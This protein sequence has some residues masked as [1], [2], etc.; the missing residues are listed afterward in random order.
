[1]HSRR[2][3][4]WPLALALALGATGAVNAADAPKITLCPGFSVVTAI[5]E[6][7]N[8]YESIKTI[9]AM[10]AQGIQLRYS[11][12]AMSFDLLSA[13][14]PKLKKMT[15]NRTVRTEDLE[16][17]TLYL[18]Q[19]S[20]VLPD[21]V[22]ETTAIGI[23][24]GLFRKLKTEGS[25][26]LGIFIAFNI[27]KPSIDRDKHPNVYDNQ[28]IA[29][30]LRASDAPKV[31]VTLNDHEVE[32]PAMHVTGDFFGDKAEFFILDD[33]DNPL[34][35]KFRIG[36]G[37][38]SPLSPD[39]IAQRK[40]LGWPTSISTDKESLQV[41]KIIAP[42]KPPA[43][44]ATPGTPTQGPESAASG[45][46]EKAIE[47]EGRANLEAIF[48]TVNSAVLR[49]E[50]D[51]ALAAI[52][53]VM[54]RHPDWRVSLEGHTDSQADDAY[55]LELSKRRAGAVKVALVQRFQIAP[56]RLATAGYGETRPVADNLTLEGRARNR[57]VELVKLQ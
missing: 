13:E 12:E 28:M 22:P 11:S 33:P 3:R 54:R 32:L 46:L 34:M 48:F 6:L 30:V 17:A 45:A 27:D 38:I 49:P 43:M 19:F 50:S 7:G 16:S 2:I 55:N 36:I 18:Q 10:D 4:W 29:P 20:E 56:V 25:A 21:M 26:E 44:S 47:T 23:S 37:A 51:A 40:L 31:K 14:P 1:M 41:V 42:C 9:Q 52:A 39:E 35:L 15:V 53:D 24:K 8:D 5:N 57:R